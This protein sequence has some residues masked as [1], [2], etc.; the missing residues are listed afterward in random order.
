MSVEAIIRVVLCGSTVASECQVW[1]A[2][3][4]G[5]GCSSHRPTNT[6]SLTWNRPNHQF[7]FQ[8][9]NDAPVPLAYTV[10]DAFA[11]GLPDKSLGVF[12]GGHIAHQTTT[13]DIHRCLVRQSICKSLGSFYISRRT[14]DAEISIER[15]KRPIKR[16]PYNRSRAPN[17]KTGNF[18]F[19]YAPRLEVLDEIVDTHGSCNLAARAA[20]PGTPRRI[21]PSH[22]VRSH[23][24]ALSSWYRS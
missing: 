7:I 8:M 21:N 18:P 16:F 22:S 20:T 2:V 10:S 24:T 19:S 6:F 4:C 12:G 17:D 13:I 15:S 23:S 5:S 11:R 9:N 3:W 14:P 1:I